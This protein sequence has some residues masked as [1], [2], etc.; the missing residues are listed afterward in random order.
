MQASD[1]NLYGTTHDA[2]AYGEGILFRYNITADSETVV[3]NFNDTTGYY[4]YSDVIQA[5]DG[6]LYGNTS[7]GGIYGWGTIF[8]YDLTTQREATLYSYNDTSGTHPYGDLLEVMSADASIINNA[9]SNDSAGSLVVTLRGGK[10]PYTYL[11]SNGATTSSIYNLT[12]GVY[13]CIIT[14]SRGVSL[15]C[16]YSILPF[17]FTLSFNVFSPCFGKRNDSISLNIIGGTSPF[18]YNWSNGYTTDTIYYVSPGTYTCTITDAHGCPAKD[19]VVIVQSAPLNIDSYTVTKSTYPGYNNGSITVTVSGGIPP[20]DSAYYLYLWSNGGSYVDSLTNLDSGSYAV[21]VTSPYGCGSVCDSNIIVVTNSGNIADPSH[22][23]TVYP[24][25]SNGLITLGFE[26]SGF[27]NFEVSD[28]LGR[29]VYKQPLN[30]QQYNW[31][32]QIDLSGLADGLYF[33]QINSTQG[34]STKKI[35]IQK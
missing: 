1:G 12:S 33:L 29:L 19:T 9:C 34:V 15:S 4:P 22:F 2:G 21:C 5:S 30:P 31:S 8:S 27:N 13:N 26:G 14:D 28:A 32:V 18:T 24:V 6:R 23:V 3:I 16:T 11:W 25:P 20:G 10:P 17:P 35:V 7:Y